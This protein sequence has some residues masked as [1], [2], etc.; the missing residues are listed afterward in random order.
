MLECLT[1]EVTETWGVTS[2]VDAMFSEYREGASVALGVAV[3]VAA[4]VTVDVANRP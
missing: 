3:D 2:H 1:A 4:D